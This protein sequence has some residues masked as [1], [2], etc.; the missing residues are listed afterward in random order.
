MSKLSIVELPADK[1]WQV[2]AL[3]SNY[4]WDSVCVVGYPSPD[5][6]DVDNS[7]V[8]VIQKSTVDDTYILKPTIQPLQGYPTVSAFCI[9]PEGSYA[10]FGTGPAVDNTPYALAS[11]VASKAEVKDIKPIAIPPL[12]DVGGLF[13]QATYNIYNN[14]VYIGA[15]ENYIQ[16]GDPAFEGFYVVSAAT[17]KV[18]RRLSV[19]FFDSGDKPAISKL[20]KMFLPGG[21]AITSIYDAENV[22]DGRVSIPDVDGVAASAVNNLFVDNTHDILYAVVQHG[23]SFATIHYYDITPVKPANYKHLGH[24][25]RWDGDVLDGH[26]AYNEDKK[27]VYLPALG[28]SELSVVD[29]IQQSIINSLALPVREDSSIAVMEYHRRGNILFIASESDDPDAQHPCSVMVIVD[30][31]VGS[32]H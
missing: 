1:F 14:E 16:T 15:E 32:V 5:H 27:Y 23:E 9:E 17:K 28:G 3:A 2:G 29:L 22:V 20:K 11:A 7:Y 24:F 18:I 12:E 10:Y 26:S 4:L 8:A 19:R 13:F 30:P 25:L 6:P 31:E 21:V